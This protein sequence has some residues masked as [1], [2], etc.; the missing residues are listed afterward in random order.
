MDTSPNI[1]YKYAWFMD[2]LLGWNEGMDKSPDIIDRDGLR[3][4][5]E[6]GWIIDKYAWFMDQLLG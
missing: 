3:S 5:Y 2:Q 1:M 4:M 6:D